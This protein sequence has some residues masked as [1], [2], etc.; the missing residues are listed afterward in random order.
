MF[1][2]N[3]LYEASSDENQNGFTFADIST[4]SKVMHD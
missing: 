2:L 1:Y 3:I 4:S